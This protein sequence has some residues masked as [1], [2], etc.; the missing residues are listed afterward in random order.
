VV[1]KHTV[2]IPELMFHGHVRPLNGQLLE[3]PI[4]LASSAIRVFWEERLLYP[5]VFQYP[6][7]MPAAVGEHPRYLA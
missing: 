6:K 3:V 2:I 7:T 4:A 1:G 5:W